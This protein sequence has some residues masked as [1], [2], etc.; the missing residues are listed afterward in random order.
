V[1]HG[2]AVVEDTSSIDPSSTIWDFVHTR[3]GVSI[4]P[5]S[6]LG[7]GVYVGPNVK[8]G[9]NTKIQNNSLIY[10][11]AV[12]G[13]GVFIGPG[14]IF[15]NDQYPRAVNPD[16]SLK[17]S[18]DWNPVGVTI[19][20][21][22]SIGAGS[23]CVAPLE[24]GEWAMIGAGSVVTKDVPPFALVVGNP[25]HQVGWVSKTGHRL[26]P[27]GPSKFV[28]PHSGEEFKFNVKTGILSEL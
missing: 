13:D 4:G 28:C 16:H 7:R 21:G 22:A 15:T 20:N 18:D 11:P 3:S 10:D 19:R 23:V 24:I 8:I 9:A 17:S 27:E 1:I 12:V 6:I 5:G 2:S 26:L 14:V 25:A